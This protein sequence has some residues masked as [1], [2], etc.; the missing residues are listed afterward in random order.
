VAGYEFRVGALFVWEGVIGY[1]DDAAIDQTLRFI[2]RAGGPRSRVAF[3]F[4]DETHMGQ[5]TMA[6]RTKRCG[7]ASFDDR[8][9][10]ALW[11][12]YLPGEPHPNA[13]VT[14]VGLATV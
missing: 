10:D 5:E 8:A 12:E 7:F 9:G 14:K 11:R 6:A 4:A 3:T 1:I 13:W 2:A